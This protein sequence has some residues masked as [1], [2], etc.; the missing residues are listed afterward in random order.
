MLPNSLNAVPPKE[1]QDVVN[2]YKQHPK[3]RELIIND[4]YFL[5][6]EIVITKV[7]G[8]PDTVSGT[9]FLRRAYWADAGNMTLDMVKA[10]LR[11]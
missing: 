11:I 8:Q 7:E 1:V 3:E 4:G 10:R 2:E 6:Y 9:K 5:L